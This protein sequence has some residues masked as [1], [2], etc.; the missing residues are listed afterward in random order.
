MH[1]YPV[2][3]WYQND[4]DLNASYIRFF[5]APVAQSIE[6]AQGVVM[7]FD[8]NGQFIG[9]ELLGNVLIEMPNGLE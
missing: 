8:A 3:A 4:W 5:D 1:T 6:M 2:P 9:L 7:D